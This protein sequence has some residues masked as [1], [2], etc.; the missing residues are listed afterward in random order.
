MCNYDCSKEV[1]E[2]YEPLDK[3]TYSNGDLINVFD[4]DVIDNIE[5]NDELSMSDL[6]YGIIETAQ[7]SKM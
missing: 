1:I 3:Y 2:I 7:M 5:D 6:F 4:V